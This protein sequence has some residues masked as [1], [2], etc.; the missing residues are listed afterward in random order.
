MNPRL[1][2]L[3]ALSVPEMR[4]SAGLHE[5]DGTIQ[6]LS[7]AGV[8]AALARLGDGPAEPDDYDEACLRA[9][10]DGARVTFGELQLHRRNP[11]WHV[12]NL[13]LACYDREY[14]P[15]AE[16]Q[17]ARR[18]HLALWPVAVDMA[19]EALDRVAAPV[20]EAT[21]GAV[22]GLAAGLDTDEDDPVAAAARNAL[23][24]LVEHVRGCAEHGPGDPALGADGL[25]RL[26]GAAEAVAVDLDELA[27]AADR[28]RG[29]MRD[30]LDEAA[31]R[32][33][34]GRPPAEL[35]P[36]LLTDH[37]NADGVLTE[38]T[39]LT[40]EV[41][42]WTRERDLA[43]YHDGEC[44]VGPAPQSRRWAMAMMSW[45][46]PGEPEG[47]SWYHVTPPDPAWPERQ[48]EEWLQVFSRTTLPAITVHEV[49]PGHFSHGRALRHAASD[50]RR[51]LFS[52]SF[53]EG[54]AHYVEELAV[55]E[56]F[57]AEDPRFAI[58]VA[59]E[60]L[61][62]VTRLA[63]SIGLHTGA[64][65]VADAARRF[66]ADAFLYGPA[67]LSEARR[68]TFDPG[69][70]RY[71]WGKLAIRRLR[72]EARAAWGPDFSLPRLHRSMLALG[73]PPLGL[74]PVALQRS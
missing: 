10:E 11:L 41:I 69:Y 35:V 54:W 7:P 55:E 39:A 61:V 19:V 32:L 18:R 15:P 58:G 29:R 13:D 64:M 27:A 74:L 67:A 16:R 36:E 22:Q 4:E 50:V 24:R 37:P 60:A 33:A 5:L 3:V 8:W 53:A 21:L 45:A 1:S 38:A 12:A 73:S 72:E 52:D 44:L 65:T 2:A 62:R 71:T 40:A 56:G 48:R 20:A 68:G 70:G 46:A 28:E 26:L 31:D 63:C 17:D 57:R 49:A 47:P 23:D 6:D 66:E 14:A 43:P 25:A 9:F 42:A 30:L 34:P 59:V 51:T